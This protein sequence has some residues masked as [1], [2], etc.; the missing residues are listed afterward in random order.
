[1]NYKLLGKL[2][3]DTIEFFLKEIYNRK[4]QNK[5]YQWIGFDNYLHEKFMEIFSNT[6][7]SVSYDRINNKWFQKAFYSAPGYG[8][9]I[10]KDGTQCKTALNISLS[11]NDSDW[12]RWYD[13]AYI[14]NL[15]KIQLS[16]NSGVYA[17]NTTGSS[18]NIEIEQYEDI[19]YIEEA[20]P[21]IGDVYLVNTDVFHSFKCNGPLDRVIIQTKFKGYPDIE[22]VYKS[23]ST[24]SFKNLI[25]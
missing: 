12:V 5:R 19:P 23:V 14:N 13:E 17:G 22:T 11:S 10:H 18:R 24:N 20:R 1:M 16:E 3:N 25:L 6:E 9:K 8:W 7:L 4:V 15:A 21:S 2:P